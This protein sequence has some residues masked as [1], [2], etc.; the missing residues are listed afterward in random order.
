M[1]ISYRQ[2]MLRFDAHLENGLQNRGSNCNVV[3][4]LMLFEFDL[5]KYYTFLTENEFG[6]FF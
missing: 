6:K 2:L 5:S 4:D 3:E 1:T